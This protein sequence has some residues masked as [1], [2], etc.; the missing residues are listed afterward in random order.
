MDKVATKT[1]KVGERTG[2]SHIFI[3]IRVGQMLIL[4]TD[5]LLVRFIPT[6]VGQTAKEKIGIQPIKKPQARMNCRERLYHDIFMLE[7]NRSPFYVERIHQLFFC[8]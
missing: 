8:R 6:C 5:D 2:S 3:S 7:K 4:Q 1:G